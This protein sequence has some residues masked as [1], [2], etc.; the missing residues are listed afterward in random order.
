MLFKGFSNFSFSSHFVQWSQ[1]ILATLV[2][3]LSRNVSV[4]IF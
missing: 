3:G 4:I 1:T 2:E